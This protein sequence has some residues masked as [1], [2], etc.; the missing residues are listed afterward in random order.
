[1]FD[2]GF[3]EMIIIALIAIIVLGPEKMPAIARKVGAFVGKA[4]SLIN[5]LKRDIKDGLD[6]DEIENSLNIEEEESNAKKNKKKTK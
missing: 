5:K 3:W 6:Y 2:F 4:T 1:M